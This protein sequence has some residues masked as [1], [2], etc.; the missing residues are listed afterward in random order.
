MILDPAVGF[1]SIVNNHKIDE[2]TVRAWNACYVFLRLELSGIMSYWI[3]QHQQNT[4]HTVCGGATKTMS[5][6]RRESMQVA[7]L[8]TPVGWLTL[9]E[10]DDAIVRVAWLREGSAPNTPLL[11]EACLQIEAYFAGKLDTFDLPLRPAG[12]DFQRRVYTAM[13]AIPFGQTRTYGELARELKTAA[14]PVGQACGSNP[15]PIVIP[16]HRVLATQGLGGYSGG[17]GSRDPVNPASSRRC[18][19]VSALSRSAIPRHRNTP[20]RSGS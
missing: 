13:S 18:V 3:R 11:R 6:V 16:C 15:I 1:K 2:K 10:Q 4:V 5:Y 9:E 20:V 12:T 8:Q 14:Q 19:F 17:G 7:S